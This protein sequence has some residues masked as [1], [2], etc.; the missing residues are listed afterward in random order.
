MAIFIQ[1]GKNGY[2]NNKNAAWSNCEMS[3][4]KYTVI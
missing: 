1:S 4:H 3:G 2:D